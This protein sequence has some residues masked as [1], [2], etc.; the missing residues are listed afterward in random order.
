MAEARGPLYVAYSRPDIPEPPDGLSAATPGEWIQVWRRVRGVTVMVKLTGFALASFAD[1][2]DGTRIHPGNSAL[3]NV[4]AESNPKTIERAIVT[5]RGMGLIW[6]YVEGSRKG[7]KGANDEYRLTIP[8]EILTLIPLLNP[9]YSAPPEHRLPARTDHGTLESR[10][11][12]TDSRSGRTELWITRDPAR[13]AQGQ[14]RDAGVPTTGRWSPM[15]ARDT[16]FFP[17][18]TTT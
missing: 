7:T 12:W 13:V 5:I 2:N 9:D 1:W 18:F 17:R 10:G 14:P 4:C 3:A 6:R 11:V 16:V 8:D 15:V